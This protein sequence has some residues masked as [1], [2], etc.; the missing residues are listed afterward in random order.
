[1]HLHKMS[2]LAHDLPTWEVSIKPD[3]S[4]SWLWPSLGYNNQS[5]SCLLTSCPLHF[6]CDNKQ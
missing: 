1:M 5:S 2:T 4:V 3:W 6:D